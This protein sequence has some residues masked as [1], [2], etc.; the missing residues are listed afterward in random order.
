VPWL[1]PS[2]PTNQPASHSVSP[3]TLVHTPE[4]QGRTTMCMCISLSLSPVR[5]PCKTVLYLA[6]KRCMGI[7]HTSPLA[8]SPFLLLT[9][10]PVQTP[11]S[12]CARAIGGLLIPLGRSN[13]PPRSAALS[14][15]GVCWCTPGVPVVC[16]C[17]FS[18]DGARSASGSVKKSVR[19]CSTRSRRRSGC[20]CSGAEEM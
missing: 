18:A 10:L 8:L 4:M 6:R 17:S 12:V 15:P 19:N 20:A 2:Q 16:A 3:S 14:P 7:T 9:G 11:P 1:R 5:F 13:T